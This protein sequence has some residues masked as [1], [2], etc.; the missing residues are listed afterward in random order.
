MQAE[1]KRLPTPCGTTQPSE[2]FSD[3]ICPQALESLPPMVVDDRCSAGEEGSRPPVSLS[4]GEQQE[5]EW[6]KV[7]FDR[8]WSFAKISYSSIPIPV[9]PLFELQVLETHGREEVALRALP[10]GLNLLQ[11]HSPKT[12]FSLWPYLCLSS[13]SPSSSCSSCSSSCSSCCSCSSPPDWLLPGQVTAHPPQ[14]RRGF[15]VTMTTGQEHPNGKG[16][17]NML[18]KYVCLSFKWIRAKDTVRS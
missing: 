1:K 14:L 18:I 2:F 16:P 9:V 7:N 10:P 5:L 13:C 8:I 11:V 3:S 4:L 6:K 17:S 15:G 12:L